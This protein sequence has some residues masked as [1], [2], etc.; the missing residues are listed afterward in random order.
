MNEVAISAVKADDLDVTVSLLDAQLREHDI[1]TA[2][3]ALR[4]VVRALIADERHGFMY[5]ASMGDRAVGL[6]YAAAHL[7]AEHG[8]VIGWLE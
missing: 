2:T 7:S 1:L 3:E 8:G 5:L 4:E 6:A